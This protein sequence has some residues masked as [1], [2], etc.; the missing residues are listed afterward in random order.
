MKIIP[1]AVIKDGGHVYEPG[2]EHE[3]DDEVGRRMVILG[4]ATSPDYL[5]TGVEPQPTVVD[6]APDNATN[7]ASSTKPQGV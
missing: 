7:G 3:V 2:V 5:P 1:S 6:I 4:W